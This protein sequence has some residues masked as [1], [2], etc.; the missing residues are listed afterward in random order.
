MR[1]IRFPAAHSAQ[2]KL[3]PYILGITKAYTT[4]VGGG[5]FP[6]ELD[7]AREG[8]VGHHLSSVGQE[9]GTVTGRARR[10]GWLDAAALRRAMIINGISGLCITKLDVLDTLD[11]VKVAVAY[12]LGA[13]VVDILPLD[14]DEIAACEPVYESLPGWR[15]STF[16]ATAWDRLPA[17]ARA[18]LERVEA[19]VG[20]PIA[21]VST[22]P[23]RDHTIVRRHPFAG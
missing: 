8:S 9:R 2:R 18:Y 16:A 15:E 13:R 17:A 22:G 14:P 7:I 19:L 4:R 11:E 10:G 6:T 20:V 3:A 1:G 23:D 5:P 12:R 21:M